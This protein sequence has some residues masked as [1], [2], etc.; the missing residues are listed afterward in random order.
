MQTKLERFAFNAPIEELEPDLEYDRRESS[1]GTEEPPQKKRREA[2]SLYIMEIDPGGSDIL[3][4]RCRKMFGLKI[5]RA[6]DVEERA[7]ALSKIHAVQD[8]DTHRVTWGRAY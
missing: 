4:D 8:E 7:K 6:G 5:G 1:V 3:R 2:D